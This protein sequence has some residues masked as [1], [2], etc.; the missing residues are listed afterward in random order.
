[1]SKKNKHS[2][3]IVQGLRLLETLKPENNPI[4]DRKVSGLKNFTRS[5]AELIKYF[6]HHGNNPTHWQSF[7]DQDT[8]PESTPHYALYLT[9]LELFKHSQSH[10]NTLTGKHLDFYYQQVL[11]FEEKDAT[12]DQVHVIFEL[13]KN[14]QRHLLKAE[15]ATFS[16]GKDQTGKE[17]FYRLDKDTVIN[18]A[19]IKSIKSIFLDKVN[20]HGVFA[21]PVANSADGLG[22]PLE[23]DEPKWFGFGKTQYQKVPIA[24]QEEEYVILPPEDRTM[25]DATVGFAF[26]S[27]I[28]LLKEGIRTIS[29]ILELGEKKSAKNKSDTGTWETLDFSETFKAY[30]SGEEQWIE[31]VDTWVQP[32]GQNRLRIIVKTDIM[33]PSIVAYNKE[34]LGGNFDTQLPL[35][36][37]QINQGH[38]AKLCAYNLLSASISVDVK[39]VYNNILE[40]NLSTLDPNAPFQP[41]GPVPKKGYEFRV[42]NAEV[43]RKKLDALSVN[44]KWSDLPDFEELYKNWPE[45][46]RP[47][48]EDF[49]TEIQVLYDKSW[50]SQGTVPLFESSRTGD[51]LEIKSTL[52]GNR[53][54]IFTGRG[55]HP[56]YFRLVD[57]FGNIVLRSEGYKYENG[58]E[59]GIDSV[60]RN[61]I[62]DEQYI[63]KVA[64][65][66]RFYF[67][68]IATNH[69][70]IGVSQFFTEEKDR[71]GSIELIKRIVKEA[72]VVSVIREPALLEEPEAGIVRMS[73]GSIKDF[74]RAEDL[75]ELEGYHRD[76]VR[77]FLKMKLTAEFGHK[78]F[79]RA[80]A[81][82]MLLEDEEEEVEEK[83]LPQEP[84]TPTIEGL[85]LNYKSSQTIDFP[86]SKEKDSLRGT[87]DQRI[88]QFF[89]I[90]PFGEAERHPFT[91]F[92]PFDFPL[93][94]QIH[95]E[96]NLLIG[97]EGVQ[98]YDS[99]N[100]LF[101]VA[102]G[103][104]VEPGSEAGNISRNVDWS[105]MAN[106]QWVKF[107]ELRILADNTNDFQTSG[108]ISFDLP[109]HASN[110]NSFM[111]HG[112]HWLKATINEHSE[113]L[114]QIIDLRTQAATAVF[115]DQKN[116]PGHLEQ[117]LK[118]NSISKLAIKDT[119]IKS[120]EQ[121]YASFG[122]KPT[123][124]KNT[125]YA[126]V[127]ERLRHKNRAITVWDYERLVL[128]KFP[129]IYK[130]RCLNY[131]D[132]ISEL[133]PG[134][135]TLI[136]IQNVRNKN[137]INPLQPKTSLNTLYEIK[138]YLQGLVSSFVT[139][140]VLNPTYEEVLADFSVGFREGYDQGFYGQQ[141]NREIKE[142]LSPWAFDKEVEMTLTGRVHKSA[143]LKFIMSRE[144][145]DFVNQFRLYH[146]KRGVKHIGVGVGLMAISEDMEFIVSM[147]D[148]EIVEATSSRAV[149]VSAENHHISVVKSTDA[150]CK[151]GELGVGHM[152]IDVNFEVN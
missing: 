17:L 47:Q 7:F 50:H 145:V 87:F 34:V 116:D 48:V 73:L 128:E 4:D 25:Q 77:G 44:I 65:D 112:L 144:Y 56:Y 104:S 59:N 21:A 13:A 26:A 140:E 32:I 10:I 54:E 96:G 130:V 67:S 119:A 102:E 125:F 78:E 53:F 133:K 81:N 30:L 27:P 135:V 28:L 99:L 124:K 55:K 109:E 20:Q 132:R 39:N 100:V 57:D 37:L 126:R 11:R 139:L 46:V 122:G 83:D 22:T 101:Q 15:N 108:I 2:D 66:G 150:A 62:K 105:Y 94:P 61:A 151:G 121:P 127:S 143:I 142:F 63:R 147:E 35:M 43:F 107:D 113:G 85:S 84:Y 45:E 88:D 72:R 75:I 90:G 5:F 80:Y 14:V 152:M 95:E 74:E 136:V 91:S 36:Q 19:Q 93:L 117:L 131:T 82:Q 115:V 111:P 38:Y 6:D 76:V 70:I 16:A 52:E 23:G 24:N 8:V 40:S 86:V 123:E 29:I 138:N 68:L 103:S 12:P 42:G 64:S 149:L 97:I 137:A 134:S 3:G 60:K 118:K 33:T 89:H 141:L 58:P 79:P 69:E 129:S 41:Y 148:T 98:P 9:F 114:C 18:Q 110:D 49:T 1:M 146:I 51:D 92:D 31:P 106:N 71:E 120:V